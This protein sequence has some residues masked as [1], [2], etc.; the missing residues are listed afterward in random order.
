MHE[1]SYIQI[2]V[3]VLSKLFEQL[4]NEQDSSGLFI[5]LNLPN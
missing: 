3:T 4:R 2:Q 5:L 1:K